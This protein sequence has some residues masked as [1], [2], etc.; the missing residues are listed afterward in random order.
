MVVEETWPDVLPS[1]QKPVSALNTTFDK[2][3]LEGSDG[4][5]GHKQVPTSILAKDSIWG[6]EK[7]KQKR[8]PPA[9][10]WERMRW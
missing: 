3:H 2:D 9:D 10:L 7:R 4:R 5:G 6:I 8:G 1:E